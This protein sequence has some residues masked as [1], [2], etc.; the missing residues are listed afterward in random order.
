[1]KIIKQIKLPKCDDIYCISCDTEWALGNDGEL[2]NVELPFDDEEF[3]EYTP[4]ILCSFGLSMHSLIKI[5][6][7]FAHLIPII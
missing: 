3:A 7:E 6:K 1:M 5:Y 2:Y 4:Y